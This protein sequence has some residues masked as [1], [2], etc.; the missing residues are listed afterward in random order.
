MLKYLNVILKLCLTRWRATDSQI[1]LMI[2]TTPSP[3]KNPGY[4]SDQLQ[5]ED[6]YHPESDAV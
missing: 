3:L 6:C 5:P 1:T 2:A 4:S